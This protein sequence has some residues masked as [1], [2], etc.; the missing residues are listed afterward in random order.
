M[1]LPRFLAVNHHAA[2]ILLCGF[3]GASATAQQVF[4]ERFERASEKN[5]PAAYVYDPVSGRS[6]ANHRS[7]RVARPA[8]FGTRLRS[9]DSFTIEAFAKPADKLTTRPR[10]VIP[11]FL[12]AS[13]GAT[14]FAGIRRSPKPH[15]Y[16]WWQA[17]ILLKG[18][19]PIDLSRPRYNGIS[20][21][22]DGSP[23][24]H[25]AFTWDAIRMTARFYLDY[26]LQSEAKLD[27]QP[28][29]DLSSVAIGG[30]KGGKT[31]AGWIDE[32]RVTPGALRPWNFQRAASIPLQDVS[33]APERKPALPDDYGHVDVRL[34][35]G[36][37][38]DGKH[39]DTE[40]IKRAFQE[41][42][43]RVPIAYQTVYF[44]EG[45]YLISDLI[46][47]RRF[48]VVRG[49]G[50]GRTRIIL[51][52]RA[53]GYQNSKI[54][55]AAFA[56]GYDWPYV[57]RTRKQRAG[58]AIG[59][60]IFDLSI[61]TGHGNPAA[62]GLDFHCNNI[63][64]V[65][66]VDIVSSDGGGLV[67]LDFKRG[68]PGPCL[69]RDV[70]IQGF[71][72]GI[73]ATHRE[74]SLVFSGI[75]LKGQ[76]VAAIRN[77]GNVLSLENVE[78]MNR[79]P[80]VLN[81]GGGLVT[82]INSRLRGGDPDNVAIQSDNASIYLRN[83]SIAGYGA[84]VWETK[85]DKN[86]APETVRR[87]S[88]HEISEHFTGPFD[89]PSAANSQGSLKLPIKQTPRIPRP[90]VDQ[91]QNVRDFE[92]LA[93]DGDWAPA[94]QAAVDAG[95]PLVY[96]PAGPKYQIKRDV[97][98]RGSVR[99]FFGG[100]P[101]TGIDNGC[102]ESGEGPAL[103]LDPRLPM[104]QFDLLSPA[105]VRHGGPTSLIFRHCGARQVSA[106]PGCG[107]L[108]IEDT[109]GPWRFNRHQKVWGRQMNPETKG[110][111]EIINDGGQFWVL[112]MKTEY[113]ST[114]IVNRNGAKTELL[115]GLMYPVHPVND[116]SLPMF[117]N[118]DSDMSLVHGVS[119]YK[120]N[121]QIYLKEVRNGQ[122][123][124]SRIWRWVNGRPIANVFRSFR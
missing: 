26:R 53:P 100:S 120:K 7:A 65:E 11:V 109:G 27:R 94:I 103:V 3:A 108:F 124:D 101:K 92:A 36:A 8:A 34:H 39:D 70:H 62:L 17:R 82:M 28:N 40:A 13:E 80:A 9:G 41:N 38:G 5:V 12:V 81:R 111:P 75:E 20:M 121:H 29:W 79:V 83:I 115:G 68:W 87:I 117:I 123:T 99:T 60:Y 30:A 63:G 25:L 67:G 2:T 110:V 86:V 10:D 114:K 54:P 58:N 122:T 15:S 96:F 73:D 16:N 6:V 22:R 24:R 47:F 45:D 90:P 23:W 1:S 35:Y 77:G 64:C 85:T 71:D 112:G 43:N 14:F 48:M 98:L 32:V 106:G 107:D 69:I 46:R 93:R 52:D 61:H 113:L 116:A 91:W 89:H 49:A 19:R 105:R 31:F 88:K 76:N 21:V 57:G 44:P 33:F 102:R 118:E 84:S 74:Y 78:S 119:V 4:S 56:V 37:V 18:A 50:R 55:R 97:I 95:K 72:V 59:S 66:N 104:F 42:D 51:K